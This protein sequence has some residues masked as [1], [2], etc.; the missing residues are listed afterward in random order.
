[1]SFGYVAFAGQPP[2]R[3]GLRRVLGWAHLVRRLQAPFVLRLLDLG[4]H[5]VL[6]DVG[7]GGGHYSFELA[8]RVRLAVALEIQFEPLRP[9]C[10]AETFGRGLAACVGDAL[11]LPF[12]SQ[13]VDRILL[14]GTLQAL[15]ASRALAE[16]K[17]VLKPGGIVVAAVL[18]DHPSI[19]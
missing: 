1:M 7:A 15:D 10:R 9:L 12:H 6:L 17:R 4:S 11:A 2:W 14:S 5:H 13:S 8:K 16:C 18:S 3:R 19:R